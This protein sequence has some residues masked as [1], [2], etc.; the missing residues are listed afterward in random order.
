MK[1][2]QCQNIF[3]V[4]VNVN[5]IVK[6]VIRIKNGK[7]YCWNPSIC[8]CENSK[9]LKS[10]ADTSVIECDKIVILVDTVSRKNTNTI[11][12]KETNTIATNVTSKVSINSH[13]RKVRL[14]YFG[15]SFFSDHIF[16]DNYY[17]LLLCK[18]KRYNIK[19]KIMNL[20]KFILKILRVIFSMT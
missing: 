17:L 8:I 5:S 15:Y 6:H 3:H 7:D 9:Y 4:T 18:T 19:S 14:L 12:T 10:I 11:A 1:L 20:K 16:D 13:G 2:N